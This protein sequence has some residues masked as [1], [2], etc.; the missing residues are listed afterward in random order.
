MNYIKLFKDKKAG[1]IPNDMTIV[2]DN[3]GGYWLY[4][5]DKELSEDD[6]EKLENEYTEKYGE[7]DGYGDVIDIMVG[8]GFNAERC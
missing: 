7:P 8:A 1:L 2:F 6:Q 5:G 3:D 4:S